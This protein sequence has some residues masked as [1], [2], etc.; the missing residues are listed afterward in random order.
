MTCSS[1]GSEG[2]GHGREEWSWSTVLGQCR[3]APDRSQLGALPLTA[4]SS[5]SVLC[6]VWSLNRRSCGGLAGLTVVLTSGVSHSY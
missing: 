3:G 6:P 1:A 4:G 2:S 5:V